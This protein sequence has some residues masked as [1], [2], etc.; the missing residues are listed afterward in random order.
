MK[1]YFVTGTGTGIGKTY[2]SALL[3]KAAVRAGLRTAMMKPVQ[4]GMTDPAD[5]DLGEIRRKAP[6]IL[7]IPSGLACPYCLAYEAS[8]QL[9]AEKEYGG[10]DFAYIRECYER[11][12]KEYA[13]DVV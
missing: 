9:A 13:P 11:I 8:P 3:A 12:V 6:Q 10:I 1:T 2:T 4:T 5:G 7:D